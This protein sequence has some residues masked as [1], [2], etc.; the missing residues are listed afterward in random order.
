MAKKLHPDVVARK[1][2]ARAHKEIEERKKIW[3][4]L[5]GL[6]AAIVLV[7]AIGAVY[8]YVII[9]KQPVAMV[10]GVKIGKDVYQHRVK[11]ERYLL[12]EQIGYV[13]NQYQQFASAFKDSPELM[14]SFEDQANQQ[15]GQLY[16][17][18]ANVAT[19]SL[20]LLVE[21]ELAAQETAKRGISISNDEVTEMYNRVAAAR[22]GGYTEASVKETVTAAENATATAALF[23]PTPTIEGAPVVTPTEV[24]PTATLNVISGDA[25]TQAATDW[26]TTVLDKTGMTGA[27]LRQLVKRQL[28]RDKL[29]EVIGE[30]VDPMALQVH[31]AHI[32]VATEDEAKAVKARLT[33]G[34]DFAT[35]AA[36]VSTDPSA[37]N[38]G[39]DLGWFPQGAMVAPFDEAAFSLDVGQI[40]DP[41]Q[42]QFGWHIIEVLAKE[43]HALTDAYLSREQSKAY[44]EWLTAVKAEQVENLWKSEYVPADDNAPQFAQQPAQPAQDSS[45]T[46]PEPTQPVD[47]SPPTPG[48]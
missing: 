45:Q 36:E 26:Q 37:A 34:E 44:D 32:L 39:G 12:D 4:V 10:N 2:K 22:Q 46:T 25:L 28:L 8:T 48:S 19:S 47:P 17:Q 38:N 40:S 13:A 5:Y 23:T 18:R 30:T 31:A 9:P 27:E 24:R 7:F 1:E 33:A 42:T 3:R 20:D 11:Y 16:A 29:A 14:K 35:V 15:V 43:E 21:E 6:I 41:V